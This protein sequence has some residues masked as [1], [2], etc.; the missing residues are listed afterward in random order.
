LRAMAA[1]ACAHSTRPRRVSERATAPAA[2]KPRMSRFGGSGRHQVL[3]QQ[4]Q[5]PASS[6]VHI[7]SQANPPCPPPAPSPPPVLPCSRHQQSR[8]TQA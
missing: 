4:Q 3:H 5:W 7:M 1:R 2:S 6:A 8:C